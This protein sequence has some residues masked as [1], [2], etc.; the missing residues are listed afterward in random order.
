MS[1]CERVTQ[2]VSV[3]REPGDDLVW[4]LNTPSIYPPNRSHLARSSNVAAKSVP[5]MLELLK[6][7]M[8]LDC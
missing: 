4:N 8:S 1:V 3:E 2:K 5:S 6:V 7:K